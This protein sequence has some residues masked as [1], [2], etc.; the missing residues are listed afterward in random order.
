MCYTMSFTEI[1]K[2]RYFKDFSKTV[3]DC[4][5]FGKGLGDMHLRKV[6][7]NYFASLS[8]LLKFFAIFPV[9]SMKAYLISGYL[10]A[11][12]VVCF[13]SNYFIECK[14]HNIIS[15]MILTNLNFGSKA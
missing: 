6:N 13:K 11:F 4:H 9:I 8:I 5:F 12:L 1:Y 2:K 15:T 14:I 7:E 10:T 3:A